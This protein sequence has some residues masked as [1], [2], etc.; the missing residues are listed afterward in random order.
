MDVSMRIQDF[1]GTEIYDK[2]V[3]RG[4]HRPWRQ[5][6]WVWVHILAPSL[7]AMRLGR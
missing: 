4:G 2:E 5:T 1:W 7:L 3:E 6:A